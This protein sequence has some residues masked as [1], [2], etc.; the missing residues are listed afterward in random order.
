MRIV[1]WGYYGTNYGDDIM[2]LELIKGLQA[3]QIEIE[4][5]DIYGSNLKK[6]YGHLSEVKFINFDIMNKFQKLKAL[7]HF[8][9]ANINIWGGGTVF[10][11]SDGDGNYKWFNII[12]KFGG[13]IG[14]V[15]VGIGDLQSEER[16]RKTKWLLRKSK[17]AV[18]RDGNSLN[19]AKSYNPDK[20]YYSAEDLSYLYFKDQNFSE[21]SVNEFNSKYILVT[22]RNL[23]NYL[24]KDDENSLMVNVVSVLE[25]MITKK[26]IASEVVLAALD[27]NHD[28]ESCQEL[29][30]KLAE[31]GIKSVINSNS[32]ISNISALIKNCTFHFSGRL[33]GSVASELMSIPTLSLS[34][35]PKVT[36]FYNSINSKNFI[37]VYNRP[38]IRLDDVLRILK[39]EVNQDQ[40][41][42]LHS[43]VLE[44]Q[45]N[46]TYLLDTFKK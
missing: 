24:H 21:S 3:S 18:F 32:S 2:L 41:K 40:V 37:D 19:K 9:R 12:K 33:H 29:N 27:T 10:T 23:R 42:F 13:N 26:G 36:Y 35:S 11:E 28:F 7:Y 16:I 17:L 8:A 38:K 5:V 20:Q 44:S 15:G 25:E 34:Y 14:Y 43:K 46:I 39:T 1:I 22:W 45:N 30:K 6:K 31:V 4:V